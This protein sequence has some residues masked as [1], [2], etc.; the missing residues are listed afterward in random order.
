MER[1]RWNT[2]LSYKK[3]NFESVQLFGVTPL[4]LLKDM[5]AGRD[6]PIR[7]LVRNEEQ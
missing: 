6:W 3:L 1:A 7:R 4:F 2:E 5:A